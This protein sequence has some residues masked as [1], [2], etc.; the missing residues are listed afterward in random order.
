MASWKCL[1]CLPCRQHCPDN[2]PH[3]QRELRLSQ[4]A[5]YLTRFW[6]HLSRVLLRCP[7]PPISSLLA[8]RRLRNPYRGLLPLV[9]PRMG[10]RTESYPQP[11]LVGVRQH[12]RVLVNASCRHVGQLTGITNNIGCDTA[13]HMSEETKNANAEVPNAMIGTYLIN[14]VV[15]FPA[16]VTACYAMPDLDA[17]LNDST[18]YPFIYI[19]RQSMS[20]PFIT[21]ILVFAAFI[22]AC[23]NIVYLAAVSRDLFA[24]ARDRGFPFSD[25]LGAVHPCRHIPQNASII[26]CF[27]SGAFALVYIGSPLALCAITSI[28]V[29]ALLQCYC[30]SIGC[31]LWRRIYQ[32]E[33][34]PPAAGSLGRWGVPTNV[35]AVLFS[36]WAFFWSFWPQEYPVTAAAFNWA[37]PVFVTVLLGAMIFFVVK[38]RKPYFGPVKEVEGRDPSP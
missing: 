12:G 23:G 2:H 18:T 5:R 35:A 25:W 36:L 19:L 3:Q 7:W 16:I 17:A 27:I 11:S 15:L 38:G 8:E 4:L 26:T 13:A 33:T 20:I 31:C 1:G 30:L 24:F 10:S 34:M 32:P 14:M 6:C 37:S 21:V 28:L 29:V 22:L 9:H